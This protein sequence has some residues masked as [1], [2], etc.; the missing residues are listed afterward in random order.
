[1]NKLEKI[2]EIVSNYTGGFIG[3]SSAMYE[4][5]KVIKSREVYAEN[6]Q[7]VVNGKPIPGVVS[8]RILVE[9]K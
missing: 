2:E 7:L 4:I 1:M 5:C 6:V 9:D 3:K 8:A